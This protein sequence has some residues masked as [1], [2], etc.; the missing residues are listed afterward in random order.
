[1]KVTMPATLQKV[2]TRSDRSV[3]LV[4]ETREL[5]EDAAILFKLAHSEGWLL[6]SSNEVE[7]T[8]VPDEKADS[9]TG[10]KTSAQRLRAALYVL[11]EQRGKKGDFEEFYR[12]RMERIIE[13]VK[14]KLE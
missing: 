10:T 11:F 6:Y 9:M 8:D 2:E 7:E 3:K 13:T 4:F 12:T 1:M 5:G 14:E